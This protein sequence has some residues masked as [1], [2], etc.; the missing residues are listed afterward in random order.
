M[1]YSLTPFGGICGIQLLRALCTLLMFYRARRF[2]RRYLGKGA[3]GPRLRRRANRWRVNWWHFR[4]ELGSGRRRALSGRAKAAPGS[5]V[6]A[7]DLRAYNPVGLP[8]EVGNEVATLGPVSGLP[9]G[10]AADRVIHRRN[11]G[12]LRRMHHLEDV[13]A[14]HANPVVRAGVL[15]RLAGAG[16]LA[17]LADGDERLR[18]LLGDEL[19]RLMTVDVQKIDAGARELLNIG[20][21]RAALRDHSSWARFRQAGAEELPL[22][23]VLLATRRPGFLPYALDSVAR[24][25]YPRLELV[26][27]LHGENWDAVGQ[28]VAGLRHPVKTLRVPASAPLGDALA[29]ATDASAGTL[30]TKMDDDDVYGDDHIWDLVLAREYSGAELVGK[31]HE[32]IYLAALHR[33]IRWRYGSGERYFLSAPAGGTL[34]IARRDLERVGGWRRIPRGVD[35][36][37]VADVLRAGG[38]VYRTHAAGFMLVRHGY[39]HTWNTGDIADDALLA[40]AERVWPGFRPDLAGIMTQSQRHPALPAAAAIAPE[41]LIHAGDILH[42]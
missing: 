21:R 41:G 27:A 30:L 18:P 1:Y 25:T 19:Y 35:T 37:L 4:S 31:W 17:H 23:S 32:F 9:A 39:R 10:V 29:A 12:R 20:M 14:Y 28:Q 22:V 26:L 42:I 15:A 7:F 34:L 16:V 8:R 36:A 38:R 6:S 24:Q 2:G 11:L 5:A 33:T 3:I 13:A 40:R